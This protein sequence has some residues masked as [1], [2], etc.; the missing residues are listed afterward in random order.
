MFI[1][2]N[3]GHAPNGNPDPGAVNKNLNVR[4]C[5]VALSVSNLVALYLRRVGLPVVMMQ[6]DS[7]KEIT[8]EANCYGTNSLFVSI[9]CN[10]AE[11]PARGTETFIAPNCSNKSRILAEKIQNQIVDHLPVYDRGVRTA[12]YY[13]LTETVAPAVLVELEFIHV[14]DGCQLLLD[15]TDD[16]ARAVARGVTDYLME[17]G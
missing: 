17:V 7:L 14:D 6:S 2:L 15:R 10:S 8:D 4:E 9:H 12:G 5:D 13:V 1:F 16:F 11:N 3:P